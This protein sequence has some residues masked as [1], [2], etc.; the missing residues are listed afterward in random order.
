MTSPWRSRDGRRWALRPAADDAVHAL[1]QS[2]AIPPALARVLVARSH[3]VDSARTLLDDQA[4]VEH[5]AHQMLGLDAAVARIGVAIEQGEHVRLV[6]D[7]DVD[8]TMSCLILHATLDRLVQRA[9]KGSGARVSYHVPDRFTEG[10]G[11]SAMAVDHAADDGVALL[12]TADIGVREHANVARARAKGLD[13]IVVDHHL[14]AGESVPPDALAVLCP[15]QTG[16]PYPN[17][18]LAACGV[19]YKL[20]GALLEGD[21][22]RDA[23]LRSLRKLV[24]IGTVADLV[25]V[26]G[27]E[28]RSLVRQGLH[29][30]N[31]DRHSVG[32]AA[33]LRVAVTEGDTVTTQTL[34]WRVAPRINAAGRIEDANAV[35]RLLRE[36]D[37]ARAREQ[38]EALDRINRERQGIQTELFERALAA[39]PD[40]LPAFVVVDGP[41][42]EGWHRGVVGIVASKLRERIDRPVAVISHIGGGRASGSVRSVPDVHA[43]H[44]LDACADLF[45]RHGGH[46]AAAGFTLDVG[47]IPELRERLC[48]WVD[49]HLE[50]GSGGTIEP[51]DVILEGG[52]LTASLVRAFGLLEPSGKGIDP[53]R[54]AIV[55]PPTDVQVR[56]GKHLFFNVGGTPCTWW[57]AA[58][59][60]GE[61][62]GAGV[63]IGQAEL[64]TWRGANR[65]RVRVEAVAPRSP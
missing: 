36:R 47:R 30:L 62:A 26:A 46:A 23:I 45:H 5:D 41:E 7:Y 64:D 28:N 51:V 2:L 63:V 34:A 44:A 32:L 18:A 1:V 20:A 11:L 8:G 49:A 22:Q 40:P 53:P 60:A 65:P 57:N 33:L 52:A 27:A 10:Y 39:V 6:T 15:P 17:R 9:G 38:A 42:A 14:P 50:A 59:H 29:A 56:T 24:A 4:I 21:P 12:V 35:V 3:D 61:L 54:V 19:A 37:P 55:G 16:C 13:V 58:A 48:A 43:V 31:H 25:D